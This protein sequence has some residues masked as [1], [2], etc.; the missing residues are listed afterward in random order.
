MDHIL[1][2]TTIKGKRC[3]PEQCRAVRG[4]ASAMISEWEIWACA[5]Q[6]VRQHRGK[7]PEAAAKR[8][9]ELEKL[10]DA[11]GVA[12]WRAIATRIEELVNFHGRGR[13]R[14]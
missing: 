12:T 5:Q 13:A 11:E 2:V 8:I 3:V 9:A 1:P 4:E 6:Q 10:G 7:A 14:H